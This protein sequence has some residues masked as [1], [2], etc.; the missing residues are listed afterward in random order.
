MYFSTLLF[1][2][3]L[4][5][6]G[7]FFCCC[8]CCCFYCYSIDAMLDE[9]FL[10]RES[11]RD[12]KD[13]TIKE[14]LEEASEKTLKV[15][16]KHY[17]RA[18]LKVH[19]DRFGDKFRDEF[20]CLTKARNILRDEALR[21]SYLDEMIV[22]SCKASIGLILQSHS[23]WVENND[24]DK[25]ELSRPETKKSEARK[26][27]I[28]L[29]IDGGLVNSKPKRPIVNIRGRNNVS[30]F[31]PIVDRYQFQKYAQKV[32]VYGLSLIHI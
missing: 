32:V 31:M 23:L 3:T 4:L 1:W 26:K 7:F 14:A 2:L 5:F 29:R 8:F 12:T 21:R 16:D 15:V 13:R 30:I 11:L 10:Y 27:K 28:T 6:N 20:E 17:R 24:P 18:S 9:Y 22:I 25:K 19:P